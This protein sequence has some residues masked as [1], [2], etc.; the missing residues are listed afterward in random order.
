MTNGNGPFPCNFA[1]KASVN[2]IGSKGDLIC[3]EYNDG[4]SY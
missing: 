1:N 2:L 3:E 4:M